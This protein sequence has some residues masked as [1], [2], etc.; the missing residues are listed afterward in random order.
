MFPICPPRSVTSSLKRSRILPS[1]ASSRRGSQSSSVSYVRKKPPLVYA[2]PEPGAGSAAPR[3][4]DK[5]RDRTYGPVP[6]PLYASLERRL[7]VGRAVL[8]AGRSHERGRLLPSATLA[9][10]GLGDRCARTP[11]GRSAVADR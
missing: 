10:G 11:E 8:R 4:P 2:A 1:S 6:E 5:G 3:V 9:A 7:F